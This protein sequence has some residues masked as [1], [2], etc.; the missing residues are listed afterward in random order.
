MCHVAYI[1]GGMHH[2]GT[3]M[4]G[5]MC[6][7]GGMHGG[8][9]CMAGEHTWQGACVMGVHGGGGVHGRRD[10]HCSGR[11]ASYWNAFLFLKFLEGT[12]TPVSGFKARTIMPLLPHSVRTGRRSTD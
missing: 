4:A 9:A 3:Y 2:R 6:C 11:Y 12:N 8:G 7:G 5:G 10:G 1:T